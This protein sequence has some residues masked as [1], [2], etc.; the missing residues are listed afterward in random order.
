[1]HTE[2]NPQKGKDYTQKRKHRKQ[3]GAYVEKREGNY[4]NAKRM[5]GW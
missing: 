2:Y 5:A 3:G 4:K 1:M